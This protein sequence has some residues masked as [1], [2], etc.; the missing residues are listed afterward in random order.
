MHI[1]AAKKASR[2]DK[3]PYQQLQK[4]KRR[5]RKLQSRK[6]VRKVKQAMTNRI[7]TT[8]PPRK[9]RHQAADPEEEWTLP[10][11]EPIR[12]ALLTAEQRLEGDLAAV[13]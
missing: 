5:S 8:R 12:A 13:M 1:A 2:A 7:I 4:I 3:Q 11:S 6:M 9:N 10:A